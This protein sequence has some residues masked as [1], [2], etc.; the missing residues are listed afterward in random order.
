M[1]CLR[2]RWTNR[3]DA[4]IPVARGYQV[5]FARQIRDEAQIHTGVVG[6]ITDPCPVW[7]CCQAAGKVDMQG[8]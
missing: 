1:G 6:L 4:R 8:L 7:L 2:S 3:S 5:P